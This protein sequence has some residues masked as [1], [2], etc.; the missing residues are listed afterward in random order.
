MVIV[1]LHNKRM[2]Q[3][4]ALYVHRPSGEHKLLLL[5]NDDECYGWGQ[6]GVA[7]RRL[8]MQGTF[9]KSTSTAFVNTDTAQAE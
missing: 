8:A 4:C 2:T 5:T 9:K 6:V 1:S 7:L 3:P